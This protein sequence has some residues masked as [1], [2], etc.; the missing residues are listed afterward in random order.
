MR[1][2]ITS[3]LSFFGSSLVANASLIDIAFY[4]S[5]YSSPTAVGAAFLGQNGDSWNSI[6]AGT[7]GVLTTY[8]GYTLLTTTGNASGV[9]LGFTADGGVTSLI[10]GTQ[11]NPNLT[12]SYLFNNTGGSITATL[13]GLTPGQSYELVLYVSSDDASTGNRALV[14]TVIGSTSVPFAATGDPHATFV[15]GSNIVDLT[16]TADAAGTLAITEQPSANNSR[17]VDLNGLQLQSSTPEPTSMALIGVGGC[18]LL[19]RRVRQT[20]PT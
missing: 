1:F 6:N 17:E 4:S 13:T 16:V 8:S 20:H 19:L 12:N 9:S 2:V 11:P 7:P 10:T 5:F 3:I 15:S 14:G 18:L